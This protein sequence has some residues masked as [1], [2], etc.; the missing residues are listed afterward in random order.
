MNQP[1]MKIALSGYYGFDNA[2]DEALLA[3]ITSSLQRLQPEAEFVVF[4]GN[5]SKTSSLH[6]FRAVYHKNPLAV[7]H[8]LCGCEL[9][10]S[11]GGSIFQDITSPFSL[12]YYISVVVLAKLLRKPV[13]FYAQGV[14]PINR[15]FSRLLMRLV[16]N[17]VDLITLRDSASSQFLYEMGIRRPPMLVTADPVFSLEP[18]ASDQARIEGLL[19]SYGIGDQPLIGVA[20]RK[21]MALDGYQEILAKVLD[22]LAQRGYQIIFVPMSYPE[23]VTESLRVAGL[24]NRGAI[25]LDQHITSQEHLALIA[26]LELMIAMRLH[27]LIFAANRGIPFAGIS[28]DP[29]VDAFL[30]CFDQKPLS[31]ELPDMTRQ[32]DALLEDTNLQASIRLKSEELRSK[33]AQNA[34]LALSLIKRDSSLSSE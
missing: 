18:K 6:G 28:Y 17:R 27:A 22:G 2:G 23:D 20:V 24:M 19:V 34:R 33:A 15:A 7:I 13:V 31:L 32:V 8:E 21:W 1:I 29:K 16:A 5:P 11:G 14:G 12:P 30:N 10:I 26:H 9:L 3:A 25:V 4:S